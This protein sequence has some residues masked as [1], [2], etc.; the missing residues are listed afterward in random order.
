MQD[1]STDKR[2]GNN[3]NRG[4]LRRNRV[5]LAVTAV[6]AVGL[7]LGWDWLAASGL[8]GIVLVLLACAVMCAVGM[9]GSGSGDD[10]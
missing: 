6:I 4:W 10:K 1:E 5:W 2:S 7:A 9:R 8:L 3:G